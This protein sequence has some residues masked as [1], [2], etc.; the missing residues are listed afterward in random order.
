MAH[1]K[2]TTRKSTSGKA[3][4]K[5]L[6]SK[7]ARKSAPATGGVKKSH[8]FC[9]GTVVLWEIRKY[10]K[11][12]ELLIQHLVCEIARDFK[13]DLRF[14]SSAVALLQE[15]AEAYLVGIFVDTNLY[16][17]RIRGERA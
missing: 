10:Q 16:A 5:Q 9:H 8:C 12:M 3:P 2:Q 14:Q 15:V 6:A 17:R 7:A 4:T 1:T 11:S 13:T